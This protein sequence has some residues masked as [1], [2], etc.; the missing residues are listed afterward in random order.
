MLATAHAFLGTAREGGW[1][2]PPGMVPYEPAKLADSPSRGLPL[3][4]VE[5]NSPSEAADGVLD[6]WYVT[7]VVLDLGP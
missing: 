1:S 6:P 4:L 5:Q 2:E 7:L 3:A